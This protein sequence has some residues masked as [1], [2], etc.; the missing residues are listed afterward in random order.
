MPFTSTE[1]ID[2]HYVEAI[3][4]AGGDAGVIVELENRKR[5]D[6][7]AF[8][9]QQIAERERQIWIREAVNDYPLAGSFPQL[10]NGE[11]EQEVRNTALSVHEQLEGA[12]KNHQRNLEMRR[13]YEVSQNP[14]NGG[15]DEPAV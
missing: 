7:A 3:N 14:P 6:L 10:L 11:T 15:N 12:F 2:Q 1:E 5:D 4:A 9:E 8:R 13:L